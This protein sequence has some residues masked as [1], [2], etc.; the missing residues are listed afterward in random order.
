M[1]LDIVTLV[2]CSGTVFSVEAIA[3]FAHYRVNK[4]YGGFGLWLLGAVFQALGFLSMLALLSPEAYI[5]AIAANPLIIAGQLC[6]Y[7][8]VRRFLGLGVKRWASIAVFLA[9][10][11]CYFYFMFFDDSNFARTIVVE[12]Y[13]VFIA[14]IIG[15]TL[16]T[17]ERRRFSSSANFLAGV[18]IAYGCAHAAIGVATCFLPPLESY[19]GISDEPIRFTAFLIPIV[20]SVLWTFGFVMMV[21]Q[22]LNA[23]NLEEKEKLRLVFDASPDGTLITRLDDGL[24]VDVNE[25]FLRLSGFEREELVGKSILESRVWDNPK[26]REAYAAELREKGLVEGR[27]CLFRRKDHSRFVAILSGGLVTID[28]RAHIVSVMHDITER[29]LAE[30]KIRQLAQQLALEKEA[31]ELCAVTDGLTGLSNRR[32]FDECLRTEFSRLKRSGQELSLVMMDIDLF[33]AFNDTYGH[34]AGDECLRRVGAALKATVGRAQDT[35]A[36]YGGEEFVVVMP[37]TDSRGAAVLAERIRSAVEGLGMPHSASS[38]APV[39]TVSLGVAS[40]LPSSDAEGEE[41]VAL[42]DQALYEA[43][44]GGRNRVAVLEPPQGEARV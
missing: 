30:G 26:D 41:L 25:G 42:A 28:G 23:E 9:F 14:I 15:A 11:L 38:V 18:F 22:R 10:F 43:K 4:A 31:A 35:V 44:R 36:R 1:R 3:V 8:G 34:V 27:E 39:V 29:K 13:S 19:H 24:Y 32:R 16:L 21:N 20:G 5:I 6:L 40:L 7:G 12:A 17:G 37:E 2:F 33:K